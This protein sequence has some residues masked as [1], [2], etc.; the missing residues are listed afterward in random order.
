MTVVLSSLNLKGGVG[1]T[2]IA[3]NYAAYCGRKGRKTLLCDLDPQANASFGILG[4][5]GWED[6]I[7]A[8]GTVADLLG[9]RTHKDAEGKAKAFD[10]CVSKDAWPN[11]DLIPSHLD[12]F[13]V[14]LDLASKPAREFKL[15]KSLDGVI[16]NY[17]VVICDCPPNLTLPTQNA[18]AISTNFVIPVSLDFLSVLGIGLLKSRLDELCDELDVKLENAGV[19]LSRVGRRA[20]HRERTED[21]VRQN[22]QELVLS[23]Q[24]KDRVAVSECMEKSIPIFDHNDSAAISEFNYLFSELDGRLGLL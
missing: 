6:H 14:D 9:V 15:R 18:L 8:K 3:V 16:E 13:T 5:D 12:L 23:G 1:K 24:I 11:V 4:V 7:K 21:D 10:E 20:K 2:T 22:F 19:I 17:D